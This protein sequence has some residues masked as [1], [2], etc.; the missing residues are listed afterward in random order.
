MRMLACV[1]VRVPACPHA[2]DAV[3]L[4]ISTD[5]KNSKACRGATDDEEWIKENNNLRLGD[6]T[7]YN[8]AI[9]SVSED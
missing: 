3:D 1:C 4:V 8:G 2:H 5:E 6:P 7:Q 9:K